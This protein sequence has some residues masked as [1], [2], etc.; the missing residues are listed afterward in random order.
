VIAKTDADGV[1]RELGSRYGVTGFPSTYHGLRVVVLLSLTASVALKWFPAGS[2]EP[3]DYTG[4]R[5]LDS[6]AALFV[7]LRQ[8]NTRG[9]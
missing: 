1:G 3:V 8:E 2:L 4:G 6:L 5:D 9:G 7:A